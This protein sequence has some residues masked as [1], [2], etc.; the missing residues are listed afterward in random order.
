VLRDRCVGS[1]FARLMSR[2]LLIPMATPIVAPSVGGLILRWTGWHG[3]FVVL[4]AVSALVTAV[5]VVAL[6]ETLPPHRRQPARLASTVAACRVLTRDR[7]FVGFAMVAGLS[8]AG[9]LAYV[10][11]SSFV[12]QERYGLSE[13]RF[14]LLFGA[15][16]VGLVAATQLNV[17]LLRRWPPQR[18]L[19]A[20]MVVGAAASL[21]LVTAAATGLGGLAGVLVPLWLVLATV[22]L[23]FPNTSALAMSRHGAVAGTAAALLG[24]VQFGVGGAAAPLVG[25]LGAG[26]VAMATVVATAMVAAAAVAVATTRRAAA[27]PV[28]GG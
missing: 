22:G 2:L 13:Q 7:A 9:L 8:M 17:R 16:A 25:L 1:A 6:P 12:L 11:G 23:A 28:R 4:A 15:G 18:I 20:A 14:G 10:A 19:A 3:V 24:A 5:V 21:A 26:P 27:V